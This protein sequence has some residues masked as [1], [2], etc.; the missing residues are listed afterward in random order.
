TRPRLRIRTPG[1]DEFRP[2]RLRAELSFDYDGKLV[3][4]EAD[5]PKTVFQAHPKR[6]IIRDLGAERNFAQ[7]LHEIGLREAGDYS[8]GGSEFW[9]NRKH[10]P[11]IIR[12]LAIEKW[13]IEAEGKLYRQSA[14]MHLRVSSG[15]DW[16]ELR[17]DV[18]FDGQKASFPDVLAA[19][20][21]GQT[22]LSF[23]M[24]RWDCCPNRGCGNMACWRRW[25]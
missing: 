6:L 3:R 2:E 1:K 4:H 7:R 10:L 8:R 14:S 12:M 24:A 5:P 25:E 13:H 21:K 22:R 20:R 9:F 23:P 18:D 19:L 15:I 16:F 11:R 17:G